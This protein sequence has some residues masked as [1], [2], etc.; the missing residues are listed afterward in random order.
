MMTATAALQVNLD[1]GPATGWAGRMRLLTG[2]VPVLVALSATSPWL[3]GRA[4]GWHSMRR[5]AWLGIDPGR[6]GPVADPGPGGSPGEA[7]AS[8]V[9]AAPVMLER[10]A[11][12]PVRSRTPFSAWLDGSATDP[13]LDRRPDTADLD[14]HLTTLFPPVRPRGYVE[15]RCVDALPARWWPA[16]VALIVTLVDDPVAADLA[17]ELCEPVRGREHEAARRGLDDAAVGAAAR[18][19]LD[20]AV[21]RCPAPLLP[22]VE[23]LAA[24]FAAGR[25]PCGEVRALVH[26]RGPVGALEEEARG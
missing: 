18:G 12:L 23:E 21:A 19:C 1:A 22:E 25:T 9:L 6:V 4:A 16:L 14:Y 15:L 20:L 26:R 17:A 8:Y 2:L 5:R 13:L 10:H 11:M 24:L 7:W 3:G